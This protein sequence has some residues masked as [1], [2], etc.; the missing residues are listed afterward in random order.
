MKLQFARTLLI[1]IALVGVLNLSYVVVNSSNQA[2]AAS[3]PSN[4]SNPV[5]KHKGHG[6]INIK[7]YITWTMNNNTI[8]ALNV[9]FNY[10]NKN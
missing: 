3:N 1:L 10:F 4:P 8:Q 2:Y 6:K 9:Y 5:K 7:N